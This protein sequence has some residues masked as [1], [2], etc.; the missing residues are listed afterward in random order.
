VSGRRTLREKGIQEENLFGRKD[1]T[2][3]QIAPADEAI[4]ADSA[5]VRRC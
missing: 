3:E 5:Y 4:E 2:E 1:E